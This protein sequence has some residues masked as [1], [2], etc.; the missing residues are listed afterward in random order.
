MD[1]LPPRPTNMDGDGL[2]WTFWKHLQGS[3]IETRAAL[4]V[5]PCFGTRFTK[6]VWDIGATVVAMDERSRPQFLQ[7]EVQGVGSGR[8]LAL[9]WKTF[10]GS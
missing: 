6:L 3:G 4:E 2:A 7:E 5:L 9:R 1:R 8:I 10:V